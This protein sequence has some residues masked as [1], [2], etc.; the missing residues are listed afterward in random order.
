[1]IMRLNLKAYNIVYLHFSSPTMTLTD[2]LISQ[3]RK[4]SKPDS[5]GDSAFVDSYD[6]DGAGHRSWGWILEQDKKNRKFTIEINY[7]AKG[8][9]RI[10]KRMPRTTQL[11]DL[12]SSIDGVL[13]FDCRAYFQYPKRT[14]AKPIVELPLKLINAPNMPF[15][16]IQGV[17]LIKLDGNKTK[18]DI[19]LD[20]LTNGTLIANISFN[21]NAKMRE[22]IG[23][24]ILRAAAEISG[25]FVS[26]E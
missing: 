16:R 7:E 10:G 8:G 25:L 14:K 23:D 4:V 17:H 15:D 9:G 13:K 1:M 3:V 21:Y 20:M 5:E 11:F 6:I 19:A 24:E 18:Y 2:E 26:K 12:L 22:T